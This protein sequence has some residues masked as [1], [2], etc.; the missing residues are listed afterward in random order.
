MKILLQ[1]LEQKETAVLAN[2]NQNVLILQ[3]VS[4]KNVEVLESLQRPWGRACK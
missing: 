2:C 1:P 3:I 4:N